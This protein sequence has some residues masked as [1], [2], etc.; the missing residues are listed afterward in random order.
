MFNCFKEGQLT[1]HVIEVFEG[2]DHRLDTLGLRW[3]PFRV[4]VFVSLKCIPTVSCS[5]IWVYHL[6]TLRH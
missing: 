3:R 1:H 4:T 5:Y 6:H 2:K